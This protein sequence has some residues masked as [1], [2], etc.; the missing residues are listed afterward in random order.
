MAIKRRLTL[1]RKLL[2]DTIPLYVSQIEKAR[3]KPLPDWRVEKDQEWLSS[4]TTYH[5][6]TIYENLRTEIF[7]AEK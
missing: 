2:L 7:F 3:G 1:E 5:L 6:K 4:Q